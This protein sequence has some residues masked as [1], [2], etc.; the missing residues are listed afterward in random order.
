MIFGSGGATGDD[1]GVG[2]AGGLKK[3]LD[4]RADLVE[5]DVLIGFLLEVAPVQ[6]VVVLARV[7][8]SS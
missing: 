2:A 6:P 5:E 7:A 4:E 1:A 8:V 3:T